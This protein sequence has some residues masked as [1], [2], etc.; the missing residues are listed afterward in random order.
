MMRNLHKKLSML[1]VIVLFVMS[2]TACGG[3][4]ETEN[5]TTNVEKTKKDI[6]TVV[7]ATDATSLDPAGATDMHS[8]NVYNEI[9][10]TLLDIDENNKIIPKLAEYT[11][12]DDVTYEFKIKKGV[13]FHNGEELKANDVVFTIKRGIETPVLSSEYGII[14]PDSVKA[15][16]DYTVTLKLKEPSAAFLA[17]MTSIT[18]FIVNEK[19]VKEAGD[20]HGMNPVGTGPYK[21]VSWEKGVKIELERFEDYHGDKPQIKTVIIKPIPEATNRTIELESGGADIACDISIMDISRIENNPNL[22][23]LEK[24]GNVIKYFGF[25]TEKKPF[26][27]ARVRQAIGYA[28]DVEGIVQSILRGYGR[29]ATAPFSPNVMFFDNDSKPIE[30][31]IEKSKQLL[32]EAGYADGFKT[33]IWVD[34]RKENVDVATIA[35]SKLTE[36]GITAEIKV[37]EWGAFVNGVY[38]GEQDMYVIGW[39]CVSP[40]PDSAVYSAFHSSMK[41]YGG[42][43]SYLDDPKIDELLDK[44][45][46]TMDYEEREKIYLELQKALRESMPWVYLWVNEIF[47]GTTKDIEHMELSPLGVHEFHKVRFK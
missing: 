35:Q 25:N 8:A 33:T 23:L 39:S 12:I 21:F 13:K 1:L 37:M 44:G 5:T 41:G 16:D 17:T 2:V 36:I 42:N 30:H 11:Q 27:D 10:E 45:R 14:D 9:F 15:L 3:G 28:I 40:D 34:E 7:A 6:L 20:K 19:A 46:I 29:V 32:A 31:N 22:Q 24:P 43:M 47:V 38:A 18:S 4:N 26:D